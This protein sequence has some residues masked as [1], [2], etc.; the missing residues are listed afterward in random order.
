MPEI[1]GAF[2][3]GEGAQS[4][5]DGAAEAV[6][7]PRGG[8]SDEGLE[9]GEYHFD[10]VEVWGIGGQEAQLRAARL[11]GGARLGVLM[12]AEIV[13]DH[14]VARGEGWRE[15]LL[16]PG[17]K[18]VAVHGALDQHRGIDPV[19]AQPGDEGVVAPV[20]MRDGPDAGGT[21]RRAPAAPRHLG[22][23]AALID[24]DEL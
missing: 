4:G 2:L 1:A 6:S 15:H 24:E 18:G 16:D 12:D 20:P 11:D 17:A 23:K 5:S 8:A 14:D 13:A 7:A 10:R 9:L 22:I 19:I 3:W 21:A